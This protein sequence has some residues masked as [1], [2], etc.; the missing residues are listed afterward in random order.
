MALSAAAG[1]TTTHLGLSQRLRN[2][3]TKGLTADGNHMVQEYD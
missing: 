2:Y 1:I 3:E